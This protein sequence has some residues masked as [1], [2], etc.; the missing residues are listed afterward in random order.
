[1]MKN[2][3]RAIGLLPCGSDQMMGVV[4]E[5]ARS[6]TIRMVLP[7]IDPTGGNCAFRATTLLQIDE[8]MADAI[9]S[10]LSMLLGECCS[11]QQNRSIQLARHT[12]FE[13]QEPG[14]NYDTRERHERNTCSR[15]LR[16]ARSV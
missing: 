15:I 9:W 7:N 6:V 5:P 3:A 4:V 1:M 14:G 8:A 11:V 10:L 13:V 16:T 12:R 2:C